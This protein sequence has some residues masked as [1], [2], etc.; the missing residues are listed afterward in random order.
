MSDNNY[1]KCVYWQCLDLDKERILL[2]QYDT[3]PTS[4][5]ISKVPTDH[6]RYHLYNF[7]HTH[8]GDYVESFGKYPVHGYLSNSMITRLWSCSKTF[9]TGFW[10][11]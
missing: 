1:I 6:A 11:K 7:K 4:S 10:P 3:I 5:L 8:E 2:D 9:L